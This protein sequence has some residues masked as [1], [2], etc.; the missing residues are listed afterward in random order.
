[1]HLCGRDS[2]SGVQPPDGSDVIGFH[3]S[4]NIIAGF[5]GLEDLLTENL[6]PRASI[7]IGLPDNALLAQLL[8]YNIDD[9]KRKHPRSTGGLGPQFLA[10]FSIYLGQIA[11][12]IKGQRPQALCRGER[13]T[14]H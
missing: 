13:G 6:S 10:Y 1:V 14:I 11:I 3:G 12:I 9:W 2:A 8:V 4:R 7:T 5:D